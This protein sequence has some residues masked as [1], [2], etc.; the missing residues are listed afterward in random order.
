MGDW[1]GEF[2]YRPRDRIKGPLFRVVLDHLEEFAMQLA[3]PGDSKPRPQLRV[4]E[5]FRK[6]IECGVSRFG[7]ARYRCPKCGESM[8]VAFSCKIR[9]LCPSCDAKRATVTMA[10]AV[11]RLLP[12]VGYRQFVLVV[13][14]RLRFLM[15]LHAELPGE[16]A[17]LLA[18]GVELFL[19][20]RCGRG[21]PVNISFVQRF[22]NRLNLHQHIHAV[23]SD[24]VFR[25]EAGLF[26]EVGLAPAASPTETEI[27][28]LAESLRRKVL[29]RFR[30]LGYL[31]A[32]DVEKMLAWPHSGFS[33]HAKAYAPPGDR[34]GLQQ[35]LYYGAAC[36]EK[37]AVKLRLQTSPAVLQGLLKPD[38]RFDLTLCNPPFNASFAEAQA[39]TKRKWANLNRPETGKNFGGQGAELWTPGGEA[40]FAWR[41]IS[42]S[43]ALGTQVF[44]V[45]TLIS[46][47]ANL[48]SVLKALER[49]KPADMRTIE[50]SQGQKKS[51][52]VAWTF[53]DKK[54]REEW[55][56]RRWAS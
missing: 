42:E 26:G 1:S 52:G 49:V 15:D 23:V 20:R 19:E 29:R 2:R 38:E 24:G 8:F 46:K 22:G 7:V 33:V 39:G 31:P 44:W 45:S 32:P 5:R 6:Y 17:S 43:A 50:M 27:A 35:L 11:D 53:L 10:N 54:Q 16:V 41:L 3:W 51:R 13:P 55:R 37:R 30:T 56:R 48:P 28:S 12:E 9:G 25:K 4:I 34:D 18:R 36:E 21:A 40:A 14:K 47:S